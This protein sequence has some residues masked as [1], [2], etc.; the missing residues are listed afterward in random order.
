MF[1]RMVYDEKLAQAAYIIGCQ[2]T[3]EAIVVDP[4]RDVDRYI[5]IASANG[6]RLVSAAETHIHADF[7]SGARE[8]AER[9][10]ATIYVSDEGGEDWK[11]RWLDKKQGGGSYRHVLLKNNDTFRVGNISFRAVHTPG[12]TPEHIAFVVTDEGSGAD[13][14]VGILSGDFLFVGDLGRP[15]LLETAAGESG[16]MEP[17]AKR[18]YSTVGVLRGLPDFV[19]VWPA[20]GAGSACG[21]AL[22]SMP[23]S[24]IGYERRFNPAVRAATDEASFV[25]FILADQPEPPVYFA[26]MKRDNKEGPPVLG[27]V[28][29]PERMT[30]TDLGRLDPRKVAILDTREWEAF[31]GG[32]IEGSLS[33]PLTKSFCTDVGSMVRDD[34]DIFLIVPGSRL[35]ESVRDLIR[36]GLDRIRGWCEPADVEALGRDALSTIEEV[37]AED[38]IPLVER[39]G[40]GLLDVRRASEHR[41]GHIPG[42]ANI[43]HTRLAVSMAHVPQA[44]PVLINC[45]SGVR[46]ARA[47]A[48]LARTGKR[49][50]NLRGGFLAWNAAGGTV[51]R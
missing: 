9:V 2:K 15:D 27:G 32:H 24:T 22:G 50:I 36:I 25:S 19:Q 38:A 21:K 10:D 17:S 31:R 8:L 49:V 4:E 30:A 48:Y 3:G 33:F 5:D 7:V 35:D 41:D 6:L 34:E 11:Y 20:H 14:P 26:N 29:S 12:H 23:M 18:L 37:S 16:A 45:R 44:E 43:A 1:M 47:S 39:G 51:S 13:E 42:T 40:V 46:S 28:P